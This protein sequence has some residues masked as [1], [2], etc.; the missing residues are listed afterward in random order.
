[1]CHLGGCSEW[2]SLHSA[3]AVVR[4]RS[5][6]VATALA[7][8]AVGQTGQIWWQNGELGMEEIAVVTP[9]KLTR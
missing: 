9:P 6:L 7:V 2:G 4:V 8:V 5:W 3:V 1:M